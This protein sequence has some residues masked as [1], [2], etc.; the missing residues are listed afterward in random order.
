MSE[1]LATFILIGVASGG[2]ALVFAAVSGYGP[3]VQSPGVS[4]VA[5]SIRTAGDFDTESLMVYND[6]PT[7][8]SSFTVSTYPVPAASSYCLTLTDPR[9]MVL[10][11]DT[12]PSMSSG[13]ASILVPRSVPSGG[14]LLVEIYLSGGSFAAGSTATV[15][16]AS[17]SGAAQT[18]QVQVVPG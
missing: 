18:A 8:I 10:L 7:A 12:C 15:S 13:S 16:V 17:S 2:S 5:P 9:R 6:G 11:E 1:Y 3:S 4:I 14:A